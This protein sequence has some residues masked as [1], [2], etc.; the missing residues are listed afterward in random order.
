VADLPARE[1]VANVLAESVGGIVEAG[2][3]SEAEGDN[4][5]GEEKGEQAKDKKDGKGPKGEG[6]KKKPPPT[7]FQ[8]PE[9]SSL[10]DAFGF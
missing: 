7:Q 3:E 5:E 10:L 1:H 8:E 4:G 6:D 9:A 2:S